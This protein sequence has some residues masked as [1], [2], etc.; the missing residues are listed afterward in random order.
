MKFG[1]ID[2]AD[3]EMKTYSKDSSA[4]A[5]ILGDYG[6]S[7]IDYSQQFE[8]VFV[9][10][11]RI[12]ILTKGGLDWADHFISYYAP[13]N[14][15]VEERVTSIKGMTYNLDGGKIVQT[16]LGKD[17]IFDSQENKY[18]KEIKISMPQVKEGSIIDLTYRITSPFLFN[19]RD[20]QFQYKIPS[21]W[22]EYRPKFIEYYV[23]K[24]YMQGYL[25]LTTNETTT[26]KQNYTVRTSASV[27]GDVSQWGGGERKSA[28]VNTYE[29]DYKQMRMVMKDIPAFKEE[30]YLSTPNNYLSK[31]TF[32]LAGENWPNSGYQDRMGSWDKIN[33]NYVKS[34]NFYKRM[35]GSPFLKKI[36]EDVLVDLGNATETDK[37]N[38][39][40]E[41]VRN[42]VRW[43]GFNSRLA[44]EPLRSAFNEGN[45]TVAEVNLI[46]A[47]MLRKAG[48]QVEPVLLSTRNHGFVRT[49]VPAVDQLNYVI[50]RAV[51]DGKPLLL[52]ATDLYLPMG[53]LPQRCLNGKGL[54][55]A[56]SGPQWIPIETTAKHDTKISIA[57]TLS[58]DG[59][60]MGS[61][62]TR[63]QGYAARSER[64]S[65]YRDSVEYTENLGKESDWEVFDLELSNY[66][67][68]SKPVSIKNQ[69]E[70]EVEESGSVTYLNPILSPMWRSNPF[71]IQKRD[72]PVDFAS[73]ISKMIYVTLDLPPGVATESVPESKIIALPNNAGRF[74][75]NTTVLGS[76]ITILN[77][78]DLNKTIFIPGEYA[79]LKEFFEQFIQM[80]QQ[81]IVLKKT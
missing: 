48:I 79:A 73:K 6:E 60:L 30:P 35:T 45:G 7:Q 76:K 16:K 75:Y 34:E 72:Y 31:I 33:E 66:S 54:V 10:H 1:K 14:S 53:A 56:E 69:F 57:A 40:Y 36:V 23:Y 61:I 22:S 67:D 25:S 70:Y 29:A 5:V 13:E 58:D 43:N 27:G 80:Q 17:G 65:F 81:L 8:V 50:C 47:S 28:Q 15:G 52:D 68:Y 46:L 18:W 4:A 41:K 20:W 42:G 24:Q 12:K 3:L 59:L 9:R 51:L 32:E 74:T 77:K 64:S 37:A 19:Y 39:I 55:I 49:Q 11:L 26:G 63:Y 38:A 62:E 44:T 78:L 21:R 71:K 2:P